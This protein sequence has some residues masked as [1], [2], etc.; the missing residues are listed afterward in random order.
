MNLSD[1]QDLGCSIR[2][3]FPFSKRELPSGIPGQSKDWRGWSMRCPAMS[4]CF[5]AAREFGENGNTER[6]DRLNLFIQ[7]ALNQRRNFLLCYTRFL[8]GKAYPNDLW[9]FLVLGKAVLDTYTAV[10]HQVVSSEE[11]PEEKEKDNL[12][13][14]RSLPFKLF[15]ELSEQD[16][17]DFLRKAR[18]KIVHRGYTVEIVE[19]DI[20]IFREP[21]TFARGPQPDD[22][23][24]MSFSDLAS[25]IVSGICA[26]EQSVCPIL[27]SHLS[28]EYDIS[29]DSVPIIR[30]SWDSYGGVGFGVVHDAENF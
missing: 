24:M 3:E 10:I 28:Q 4:V 27:R 13:A 11:I 5:V 7:A 9:Y 2:G 19:E 26:S 25:G 1:F 16:W 20:C 29:L 6:R 22:S 15:S 21:L 8:I 17:W 30:I 18:N 12:V 14:P 23:I